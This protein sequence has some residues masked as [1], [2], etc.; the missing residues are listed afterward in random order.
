MSPEEAAAVGW[1]D[2]SEWINGDVLYRAGTVT[3]ADA[4][5]PDGAWRPV[6]SVMETLA[7]LHGPGNVRLVAWFDR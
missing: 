4:V 2:G 6:W 5:P 1:P 7:S 3:S